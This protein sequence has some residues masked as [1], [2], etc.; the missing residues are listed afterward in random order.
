VTRLYAYAGVLLAVLLIG[1]GAGWQIQGW[2]AGA[3][4]AS[5]VESAMLLVLSLSGCASQP[6]A[7]PPICPEPPTPPAD[8]VQPPKPEG[9][10][11]NK[12]ETILALI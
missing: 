8:L 1:F 11:R 12:L 9:Y 4:R 7:P 6:V 2:R 3:A 10:F 5:A